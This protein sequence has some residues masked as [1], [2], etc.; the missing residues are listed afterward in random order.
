VVMPLQ[1]GL[2]AICLAWGACEM[3]LMLPRM[4]LGRPAKGELDGP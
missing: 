3:F 4:S 1:R 2:G